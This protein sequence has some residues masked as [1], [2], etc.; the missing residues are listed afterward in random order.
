V[1]KKAPMLTTVSAVITTLRTVKRSI[2]AA[3]KGATKPYKRTFTEIA[4]EI[5]SRLQPKADSKGMINTVGA[6]LNPAVM[7]RVKKVTIA[8]IHAG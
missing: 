4:N 7:T 5:C 6:D 3:A 1:V 8:A 2:R